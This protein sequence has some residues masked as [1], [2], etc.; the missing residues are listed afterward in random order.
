MISTTFQIFIPNCHLYYI[1]VLLHY[2]ITVSHFSTSNDGLH[3]NKKNPSSESPV[4]SG[5]SILASFLSSFS[6]THPKACTHRLQ[7]RTERAR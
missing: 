2:Y 6:L 1:T 5:S 7:W 3:F 4:W